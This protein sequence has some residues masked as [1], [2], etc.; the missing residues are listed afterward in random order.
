MPSE[1]PTD[2]LRFFCLPVKVGSFFM[3]IINQY[4]YIS[5]KQLWQVMKDFQ[6]EC[7]T[8][9]EVVVYG[10]LVPLGFIGLVI[11]ERCVETLI[12]L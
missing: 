4:I 6:G 12:G 7:F 8:K 1:A 10:G 5:M 2:F 9:K 3:L 11:V